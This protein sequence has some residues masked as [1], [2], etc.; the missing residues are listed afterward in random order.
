MNKY[1]ED[2]VI[3]I[4]RSKGKVIGE[5]NGDTGLETILNSITYIQFIIACEDAFDIEID[6]D[7]LDMENMK[8]IKDV[9]LYIQDIWS[10]Q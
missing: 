7:H 4:A 5:I 6:D 2:R 10:G 3:D 8:T 9:V 1:V